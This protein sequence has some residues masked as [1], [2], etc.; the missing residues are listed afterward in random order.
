MFLVKSIKIVKEKAPDIKL[1]LVGSEKN[2]LSKV[3]KTIRENE[4]EDNVFIFGFVSDEQI[5]YLYKHAVAMIM[6][7]SMA[8]AVILVLTATQYAMVWMMERSWKRY[9]Q[10]Y[11]G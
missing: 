10:R 11:G 5:T 1:V 3:K 6:P 4:L 9:C 7:S 8:V 2:S